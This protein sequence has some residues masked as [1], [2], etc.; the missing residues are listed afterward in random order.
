MSS[1][2]CS[3]KSRKK[4]VLVQ[5]R[6]ELE[7]R[8]PADV[9]G[10]RAVEGVSDVDLAA[11]ERGGARHLVGNAL[12][13]EAPDARRLAPVALEGLDRQLDLALHG[14]EAVSDQ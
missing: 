8:R 1:I 12:D 9:F 4:T 10:D 6:H 11:L 3:T 7:A 2:C 13:H 5:R 14:D